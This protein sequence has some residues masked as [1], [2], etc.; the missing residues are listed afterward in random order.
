M[1]G[2]YCIEFFDF[3]LRGK[4]LLEHT[5]LFSPNNHEKNG[6]ILLKYFK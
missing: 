6:K 3:M 1:C 2:Y 4:N 5:N